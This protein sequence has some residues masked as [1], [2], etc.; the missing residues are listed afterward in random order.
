MEKGRIIPS[1]DQLMSLSTSLE[2][3]IDYLML[4]AATG[5]EALVMA[6]QKRREEF[7]QEDENDFLRLVSILKK[8]WGRANEKEKN[9]I[10]KQVEEVF[11]LF[12]GDTRDK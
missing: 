11:P 10:K 12:I 4:G 1:V 2:M 6:V 5:T 7:P 9:W 8:S 3:T